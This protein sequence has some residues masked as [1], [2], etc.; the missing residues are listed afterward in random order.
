[1]RGHRIGL[2][3]E[4]NQIVYLIDEIQ[5]NLLGLSE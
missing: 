1:M 5:A 3:R 2:E 4:Q